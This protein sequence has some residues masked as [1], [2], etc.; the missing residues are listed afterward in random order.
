MTD[1]GFVGAVVSAADADMPLKPNRAAAT[2]AG[3]L[4]PVM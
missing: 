1:D 4:C 2:R 3:K